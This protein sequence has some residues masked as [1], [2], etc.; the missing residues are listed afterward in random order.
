[1]K[2]TYGE[3][4]EELQER[5]ADEL[6]DI[7]E[8][9]KKYAIEKERDRI[10]QNIEDTLKSIEAGSLPEPTDNLDELWRRFEESE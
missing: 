1:M 4:I 6:L 2:L 9:A 7:A 3:L 8:V 10:R 5:P